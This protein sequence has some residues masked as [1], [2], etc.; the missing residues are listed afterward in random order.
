MD[1]ER[2]LVRSGRLLEAKELLQRMKDEEAE[3]GF[4]AR[5]AYFRLRD[6]LEKRFSELGGDP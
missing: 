5:I 1:A 4:N 3:N 6:W 2:D